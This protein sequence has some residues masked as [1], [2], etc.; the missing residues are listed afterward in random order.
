MEKILI[1]IPH[2]ATEAACVNAVKIFCQTGSHFLA[3]ADWDAGCE[4]E[5]HESMPGPGQE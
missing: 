5:I 4:I 2:E 1:E 3:D